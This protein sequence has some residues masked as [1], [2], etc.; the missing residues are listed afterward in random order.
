MFSLPLILLVGLVYYSGLELHGTGRWV[1][2]GGYVTLVGVIA[3]S[4]L[5]VLRGYRGLDSLLAD[6]MRR[7][8]SE[9]IF[10]L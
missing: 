4:A 6:Y 7:R 9:G 5:P 10:R 1:F 2:Y 8:R 3:W